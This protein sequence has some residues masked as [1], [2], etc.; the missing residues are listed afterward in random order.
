MVDKLSDELREA[1]KLSEG[2][3]ARVYKDTL[4]IDTIGYGF[5]IKDLYIDEDIAEQILE[6][7]V[8]KL[9]KEVDSRFDWFKFMPDGIKEVVVEMCYQ[10]GV[11]GFSKFKK[12]I[13]LLSNRNF[14]KASTEMLDSLWAKQT[15]KR[16]E[17]LSANMKSCKI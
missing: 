9:L 5:A 2:Y 14:A 13:K 4:G 1:V 3:R 16:A 15:P 6:K 17:S 7:K 10:L 12:T 11:N 8:N